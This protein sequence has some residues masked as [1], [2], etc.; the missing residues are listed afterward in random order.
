MSLTLKEQAR[1]SGLVL[2]DERAEWNENEWPPLLGGWRYD[3]ASVVLDHPDQDNNNNG[4]TVVVLGGT[5]QHKGFVNSVLALDLAQSSKQW[6]EGPPMNQKRDRHAAV[7]CNGGIYVI[8]GRN[9]YYS[10]L[11]CVE[12]ID[13]NDLVQ[14][15]L[16]NS[17]THESHWTT[18]TCRLT[19]ER[20]GCCAV[21]VHN[22]Y[23]VVVGGF[24][25][26]EE[27]SSVDIIDTSNQTVIAGPSMT[28]PRVWCASAVIGHR[29]FVVGGYNEG[30]NLDSVEILDFVKPWH[31]EERNGT[32]STFISSLSGWTTHSDLVLSN[33]RHSCAVVTVGSCLVVAGVRSPTVEVMDT[34]RNLVWN[35]PPFEYGREDGSMVTAANQV[36]MIGGWLNPAC[37]TLSLMD[38]YTWCFC[39]LCEQHPRSYHSLEGVG[40]RD[41]N[42]I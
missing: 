21:A 25:G 9:N 26:V 2:L 37:A 11:D 33:P 29:I 18:L 19:T 27:L 31:K 3:H 7:V 4:Q 14:S 24:N 28:V 12:R 39:R 41:T 35:L 16:T 42:V 15:S 8:G 38:K 32:L 1:Q 23:I 30:G 20:K 22:R 6:R 34:K 17:T 13:A 36:A 40:I 10:L 5:Q